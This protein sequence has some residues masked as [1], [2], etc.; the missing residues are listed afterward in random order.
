MQIDTVREALLS[1]KSGQDVLDI[2]MQYSNKRHL[3][4]LQ[5]QIQQ[6]TRPGGSDIE[7]VR[8]LKE[9]F[10][11]RGLDDN[12]ILEVGDDI[13][14]LS[15]EQKI[16][17]AALITLGVV[18]EPV[19]LDGCE[20]HSKNY[21]EIEMTTY[22]PLLRRNIKLV[23]MFAPK[24]GENSQ[25]VAKMVSTFDEAVNKMLPTVADEHGIDPTDAV[26]R[27]L[28]PNFYVGDEGGALW[29]GLC[30]VK[31]NDVKNKTVADKFHIKQDI[32]RHQKYFSSTQDKVKFDNLMMDA[33]N[34]AT[35]VQAEAA[36][37]ALDSLIEKKATDSK[38]MKNFKVWWWRR[39]IRWQRWCKTRPTSSAS[40]EVANAKSISASGYRKRLLDIV[41][42]ECSAAL[43]ETAEIHRQTSGLKTIGRGPSAA[44]RFEQNQETLTRD[45]EAS[46]DA[47]QYIAENADDEL[48]PDCTQ[49]IEDVQDEYRVNTRDTHRSDKKKQGK[50]TSKAATKEKES[51]NKKQINFFKKS[52]GGVS[53][54]I[55]EYTSSMTNFEFQVLDTM[56]HLQCV[57]LSKDSTTCSCPGC[58]KTCHH[59]VWIF[60]NVFRF[61]KEQSF[62][63]KRKFSQAEWS[64]II[65]AF[66]SVV[67]VTDVQQHS[68][69][70]PTFTFETKKTKKESKCASCKRT[71][72]FGDIQARTDGPY[73]TFNL[74]WIKRTFFYCPRFECIS[75]L[76]RNS[77]IK[78][79]RV[80]MNVVFQLTDEQR[81]IVNIP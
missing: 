27:G 13:V 56:G 72:S 20:S 2:A 55:L 57:G 31:G 44:Q 74:N 73:R 11:K 39:K 10:I 9:D 42:I 3:D 70:S 66:P 15:S 61:A 25:N 22:Y 35:S 8:L 49:S 50:N 19:S 21:T 17:L 36:E 37:K 41:T 24:P 32:R 18:D 12:M 30:M 47:M 7:A 63:Y 71:I 53:M 52:V 59:L 43:L 79:Y 68:L 1:E 34:A 33:M 78:P 80:G 29:K 69:D 40:A 64:T 60:H 46:A 14:I 38:K 77:F 67:P 4:H 26:G 16:R 45:R 65:K 58:M 62:I 48:T 54:D 75:K 76:P 6:K 81:K 23:S 51:A 28:D 5:R